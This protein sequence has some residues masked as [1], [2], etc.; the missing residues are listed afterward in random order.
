MKLQYHSTVLFCS[1]IEKQREFYEKFLGQKIAQDLG[2]CLVFENGFTLWKL[3]KNYPI[4]KELGYTYEPIGNRNLEL[5]FETE[6]FGDAV[7][8]VLV[9]DL[10]MLHNVAE[11]EW[12]QYTIRF[13]DPEGNLLEIGETLKCMVSRMQSGG[14]SIEEIEKKSGLEKRFIETLLATTT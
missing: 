12:G 8:M 10:R 6:N 3:D 7:E 5:C 9:N 2:A 1:D 4:S 13:Y 14:M 11:E